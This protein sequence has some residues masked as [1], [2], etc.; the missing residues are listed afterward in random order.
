MNKSPAP[1]PDPAAEH[2]SVLAALTALLAPLA[3]LAVAK[4]LP[5][6]QVEALV[7]L[8]FVRAAQEALASSGLPPHRRVSRI[9]TT[10]GINRRE[11][12][13]LT[14]QRDAALPAGG[15]VASEVFTR[16][17]ADRGL[18][19][20]GGGYKPLPRSGDAPSF[21][22]LA[23]S[24]T[25][26]VHP[27]SVLEELGRLGLVS[28][29][30]DGETVHLAV[31]D[32]VPRGDAGRMLAFFADNLGDHLSGSVDN[33]LGTRRHFDQA[34]F[35]DELSAQ[36]LPQVHRFVGQQWKRL[37]DEA[38]PLLERCIE[39]DRAAG[40]VQDRRVRIGLYGYDAPMAGAPQEPP[41]A[42]P[43]EAGTSGKGN[44]KSNSNRKAAAAGKAPPRKKRRE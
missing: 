1:L 36:A 37:L 4:G 44:G 26:D 7:R 42:A 40:R 38:V 28:L 22:A 31:D 43:P 25:Q 2:E 18:R 35:A 5:A 23:R 19:K 8:A 33:L 29:S 30:E 10:T 3:R 6:S 14:R 41:A 13:R 11:V 9:A 32:F 24:V 16:W 17:I 34:V 15:S 39:E 27:R 20:R 21:E 12:T